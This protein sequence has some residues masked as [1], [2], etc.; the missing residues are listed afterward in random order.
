MHL[1]VIIKNNCTHSS[2]SNCTI[3][4]KIALG[5]ALCNYL[6]VTHTIIL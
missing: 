4:V 1:S 2:P 3:I 6:T 5:F